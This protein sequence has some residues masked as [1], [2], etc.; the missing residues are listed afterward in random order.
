MRTHALDQFLTLLATAPGDASVRNDYG[1]ALARSGR[2]GEAI[3][4]YRMAIQLRPGFI[5]ALNNLGDTLVELN[6]DDEA[7]DMFGRAL[8]LNDRSLRAKR[9]LR[10]IYERRAMIW[11]FWPN[12]SA[13]CASARSCGGRRLG[14]RRCGRLAIEAAGRADRRRSRG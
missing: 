10:I 4:Q 9:G 11:I 2:L 1:A 12:W 13:S 8:A 3:E 7:L 14:L 5:I 6:R